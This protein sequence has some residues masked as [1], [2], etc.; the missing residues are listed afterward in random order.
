MLLAARLLG[1]IG[2]TG[3]ARKEK[4]ALK[5]SGFDGRLFCRID[6]FA[7]FN[8]GDTSRDKPNAA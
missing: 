2:L 6:A 4:E 5:D 8:F 1:A 3:N 7:G